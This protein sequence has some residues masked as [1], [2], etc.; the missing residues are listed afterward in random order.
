MAEDVKPAETLRRPAGPRRAAR[1]RRRCRRRWPTTA[2]SRR[3]RRSGS[4]TPS[5]GSRSGCSSRAWARKLEVLTWGEVGKP[6]LLFVHGNSAHADWWSFIA[7]F[8]AERLPGGLDVA[9]RHGRVGL[10]RA[11]YASPT[12]PRTPRRWPG[13]PG[14]TR[15]AASRS[16][17]ATRS[18]A[19]RCSSPPC[20]TP[21][22]CTRRSWSTPASARRRR[23]WRRRQAQMEAMRN[24]PTVDRPSRVYR[25]PG[26]GAGAASA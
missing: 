16:T 14:S 12:S 6:G 23:S 20:A 9:G 5:P 26:G 7:P 21:S 4:R 25:D 3:P 10:A 19:A 8:F 1:C 13:P 11:L 18:A 17:S 24:I 15:A 2:A 22:G